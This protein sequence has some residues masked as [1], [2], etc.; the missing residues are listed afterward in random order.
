LKISVERK[1]GNQK[2][3]RDHVVQALEHARARGAPYCLVAYDTQ[4]NL[5]E[6]QKPIYLDTEDG[7]VLAVAD[8]S[9][10]G[11]KTA[12][13]AFEVFQSLMPADNG[14]VSE[15]IDIAAIQR[16]VEEMQRINSIIENLRKHNNCTMKN[17]EKIRDDI[18]QLE[19]GIASYQQRLKDLLSKRATKK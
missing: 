7:I 11:W 18:L 9:S 3:A 10:G 4:E 17:S 5:T 2:Y 15:E 8:V 6:L 16:T 13:E 12:R 19:Q 1:T 14:S